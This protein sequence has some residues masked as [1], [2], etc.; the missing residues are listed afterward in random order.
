VTVLNVGVKST[1]G[2]TLVGQVSQSRSVAAHA[3]RPE[4]IGSSLHGGAGLIAL[5][6]YMA[7]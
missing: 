5:T 6:A 3:A 2:Q 7:P 4:E 1:R